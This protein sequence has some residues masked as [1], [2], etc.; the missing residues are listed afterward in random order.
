MYNT[1]TST[2]SAFSLFLYPDFCSPLPDVVVASLLIY[3][4]NK[5]LYTTRTRY[6]TSS[7]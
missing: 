5:K 4:T 1:G 2:F 7:S 3:Y 6:R